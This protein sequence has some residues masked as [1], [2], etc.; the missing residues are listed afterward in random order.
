KRATGRRHAS[1]DLVLMAPVLTPLKILC[2]GQNYRTHIKEQHGEVPSFPLLFNKWPATLIGPRDAVVLP[3]ASE[4]ADWEVELAF[5]IGTRL[6]GAKE[7]E[8]AR[9]IA[10]YT[11]LNDVSIRDWHPHTTQD[12]PGQTL[13]SMTPV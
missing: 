5:Y 11:I 3:H 9:A 10:G 7:R 13:Q 12:L 6:R 1:A 2:V 8:A 4:Q